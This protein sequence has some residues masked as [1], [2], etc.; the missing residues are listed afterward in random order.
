MLTIRQSQIN[1]MAESSPGTQMTT[2][3]PPDATWIEVQLV[4]QDQ[5]PVPGEK[6][7]IKLPDSS[8]MEG[9]LDK[10]GKVRFD[11]ITAGQ[12]EITFPDI[13]A[14]EWGPPSGDGGGGGA[15]GGGGSSPANA[16]DSSTPSSTPD[17]PD[18]A[19]S[20]EPDS[21]D[22]NTSGDSN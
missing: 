16:T 19:A 18:A 8:I 2:P 4:D 14:R 13:D 15:G 11:N 9:A 10:D 12:A 1:S 5:N 22:S 6:Y 7:H 21:G 17:S 3:C 20:S